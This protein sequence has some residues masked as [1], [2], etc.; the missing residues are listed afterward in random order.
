MFHCY[1]PFTMYKRF[2]HLRQDTLKWRLKCLQTHSF[3]ESYSQLCYIKTFFHPCSLSLSLSQTH[4]LTWIL[5]RTHM[6]HTLNFPLTS[7]DMCSLSHAH[8][9]PSFTPGLHKIRPAGQMWPAEAFNLAR[10]APNFV[11][12]D[13][14]LNKC[15]LWI[16]III[17]IWPLGKANIFLA[18]QGI[19][20]VHLI[21]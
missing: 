9:S 6:K 14:F 16:G 7:T 2:R 15:T 8:L 10:L 13:C 5:S 18:C 1:S 17:S 3:S 12:L 4:T 21:R 19:W 20:V 11:L